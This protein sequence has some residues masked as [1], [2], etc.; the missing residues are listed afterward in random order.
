[1]S[2]DIASFDTRTNSQ[3]G[4]PMTLISIKNRAPIVQPAGTPV[5]I[6]LFGR[7]SDVYRDMQRDLQEQN[8]DKLARGIR[9]NREERDQDD[10][11]LLVVCT[12]AW[13]IDQRDGQAFPFTPEN[14]RLLWSDLRFLWLR[15]QAVAF[16]QTDANFLPI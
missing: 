2:F 6:T 14:A 10:V 4:V 9:P 13:T 15:D 16:I 11:E 8:T 3:A 5:T 7:T 1:M 12:K